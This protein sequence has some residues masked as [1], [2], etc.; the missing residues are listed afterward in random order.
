MWSSPEALAMKSTLH[1]F[2]WAMVSSVAR[3]NV[4][5]GSSGKI[6]AATSGP[7]CELKCERIRISGD[8]FG[9]SGDGM[10]RHGEPYLKGG[11]RIDGGGIERRHSGGKGGSLYFGDHG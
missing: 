6:V 11:D 1:A 8:A 5:V 3:E 4:V 2:I 10:E 9:S 7:V